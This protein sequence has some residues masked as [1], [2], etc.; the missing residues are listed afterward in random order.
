MQPN[1]VGLRD[2]RHRGRSHRR[3]ADTPYNLSAGCFTLHKQGN[4]ACSSALYESATQTTGPKT[5]VS[6]PHGSLWTAT[7]GGDWSHL[8]TDNATYSSYA[9]SYIC[10][11]RRIQSN[12]PLPNQSPFPSFLKG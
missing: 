5:R 4:C 10:G 7:N 3:R 11:G 2:S 8:M 6:L 12:H 9:A 1:H